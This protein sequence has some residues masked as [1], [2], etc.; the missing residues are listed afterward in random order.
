MAT[1]LATVSA[2]NDASAEITTGLDS[3][4]GLYEIHGTNILS[5][6]LSYWLHL[7]VS[8]DGGSTWK[9]AST[10]YTW[11]NEAVANE[12]TFGTIGYIRLLRTTNSTG[13]EACHFIGYVPNPS[14]TSYDKHFRIHTFGNGEDSNPTGFFVGARYVGSTSAI[15]GL[16]FTMSTGNIT[17]E[18]KLYGIDTTI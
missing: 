16:R 10:D 2:S 3:T 8:T 5:H 15:D 18:F 1:L 4:Y 12:A 17:G 6:G 9:T 13:L 7:H 11:G 14:Q